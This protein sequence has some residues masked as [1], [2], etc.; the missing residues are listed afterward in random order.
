MALHLR[1]AKN[2]VS[3]DGLA[4]PCYQVLLRLAVPKLNKHKDILC[5]RGLALLG[6]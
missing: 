1:L 3:L 5:L 4:E 2:A 6:R